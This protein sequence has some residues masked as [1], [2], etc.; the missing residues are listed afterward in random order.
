MTAFAILV[1]SHRPDL[2]YVERLLDSFRAHNREAIPLYLVVPDED[3][4]AFHRLAQDRVTLLPDSTFA[5]HLTTTEVAGFSAGYINQEIIKLCF[6]EAGFADNYL[7]LDSDAEF[8][9]DFGFDD[10]MADDQTPYTFLSEDAALHSEPEYYAAHWVRREPL[11]KTIANEVGLEF[12]SLSTVHGHAV[13]SSLVLA[14]F[15]ENFLSPR[16]WDYVDAL[17]VAPLEPTWYNYWLKKDRTI[18]IV[19]RE[20]IIKTFHDSTQYLDYTLRGLTRSDA[21]QGYAAIVLNSNFSSGDGVVSLDDSP[22][23]VLARYAPFR[24]LAGATIRRI[25][26]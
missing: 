19:A 4:N 22:Q 26:T 11:L 20:P 24:D 13:F 1:K 12:E 10:F 7:C 25:L 5:A 9:R 3:Q 18:P 21:A 23:L 2:P 15:V 16:R 14:S 17:S 6:W 8:V